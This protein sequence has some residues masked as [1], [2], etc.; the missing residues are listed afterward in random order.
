VYCIASR[1]LE[2][3]HSVG[4]WGFVQQSEEQIKKLC[5]ELLLIEDEEQVHAKA[6]EL[7]TAIRNHL[8]RVYDGL[9]A[10]SASRP[11]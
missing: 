2:C 11:P 6:H 8:K 1:F 4:C 5:E 3:Q 10:M 9:K 7:R